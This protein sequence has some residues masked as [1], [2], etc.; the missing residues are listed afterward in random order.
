MG[1]PPVLGHRVS[2]GCAAGLPREEVR[3]GGAAV[4]LPY[5]K[6]QKESRIPCYTLKELG[7]SGCFQNVDGFVKVERAVE[8]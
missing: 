8:S 3:S 5:S 7:R 4:Q 2:R 1:A 6:C